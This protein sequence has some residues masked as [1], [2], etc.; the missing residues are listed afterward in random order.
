M[1]EFIRTALISVPVPVD[2]SL[3]ARLAVNGRSLGSMLEER[4]EQIDRHGYTTDHDLAHDPGELTSAAL[5]YL[6]MGLNLLGE[7]DSPP[8]AIDAATMRES[9]QYWPWMDGFRPSLDPRVNLAK[10][11]AL[12]LA[13]MDRIDTDAIPA[14]QHAA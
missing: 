8:T 12:I 13:A 9:Q 11:G 6:M 5:S 3:A 2:T 4:I 7:V 10:A 1:G 14:G